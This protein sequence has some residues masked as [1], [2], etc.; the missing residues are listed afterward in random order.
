MELLTK[1]EEH[2]LNQI[3]TDLRRCAKK[4]TDVPWYVHGDGKEGIHYAD[5]GT[6]DSVR[7]YQR[8]NISRV[9][10]DII[11]VLKYMEQLKGVLSRGYKEMAETRNCSLNS[12]EEEK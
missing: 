5:G 6:T 9:M 2:A 7:A 12:K 8:K 11:E 10:D 4:A 1:L 3:A